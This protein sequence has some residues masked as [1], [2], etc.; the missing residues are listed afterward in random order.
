MCMY[1]CVWCVWC[2]Y[3][4]V[5]M[6][7][8]MC[9]C[10]VC[11]VCMCMYVCVYVYV[12]VCVTEIRFFKWLYTHNGTTNIKL[13]S[14][15]YLQFTLLSTKQLR[16]FH[17]AYGVQS[18]GSSSETQQQRQLSWQRGFPNFSQFSGQML[19]QLPKITSRSSASTSFPIQHP[20]SI[21]PFDDTQLF[22]EPQKWNKYNTSCL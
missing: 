14:V 8:C 4:C 18:G 7:V 21:A 11:V 9:V 17:N 12:C 19:G 13:M 1:V 20:L 3:V 2:V 15:R 10:V 22:N 5:C 16:S 6:C